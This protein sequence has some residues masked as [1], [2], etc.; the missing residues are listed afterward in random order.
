LEDS[1]G[2]PGF[3]LLETGWAVV[4]A[5]VLFASGLVVGLDPTG[6]GFCSLLLKK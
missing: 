4:D 1:G 5:E 2:E 6:T 3:G